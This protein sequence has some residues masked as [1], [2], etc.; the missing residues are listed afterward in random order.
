MLLPLK[1]PFLVVF[2]LSFYNHIYHFYCNLR[3]YTLRPLKNKLSNHPVF[4]IRTTQ[5]C[6]N[7]AF[8]VELHAKETLLFR[9]NS[10]LTGRFVKIDSSTT[11]LRSINGTSFSTRFFYKKP[12]YKEP[13]TRQPKIDETF[14]TTPER[15]KKLSK[16][17]SLKSLPGSA[18]SC[19]KTM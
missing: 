16:N 1:I 15:A 2:R 3:S 11:V 12:H 7:C 17:M 4:F 6:F 5:I 18:E 10:S 14:G 13:C 8:C 19:T 9:K